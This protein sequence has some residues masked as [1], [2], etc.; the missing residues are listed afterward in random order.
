[1]QKKVESNLTRVIKCSHGR[2]DYS[3]N[4]MSQ[5]EIMSGEYYFQCVDCGFETQDD[6]TM[7]DHCL[8]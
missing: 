3:E 6:D 5:L 4:P 7:I 1:M 2:R 8:N